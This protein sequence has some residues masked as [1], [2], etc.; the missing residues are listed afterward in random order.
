MC[1]KTK[2]VAF[3]VFGKRQRNHNEPH[4]R[5]GGVVVK[6]SPFFL[7]TRGLW[8]ISTVLIAAADCPDEDAVLC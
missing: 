1:K 8:F 6:K 3:A 4:G 2:K 7:D 5:S